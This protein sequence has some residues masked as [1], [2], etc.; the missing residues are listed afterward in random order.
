MYYSARPE[1]HTVG[2]HT[3][4][5]QNEGRIQCCAISNEL[6]LSSEW[7]SRCGARDESLFNLI[8]FN[9]MPEPTSTTCAL[10]VVFN[11]KQGK[12]KM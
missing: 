7:G 4:A 1:Q 5:P 6:G 9:S 2:P 11:G 12:K 3:G 8:H 10:T